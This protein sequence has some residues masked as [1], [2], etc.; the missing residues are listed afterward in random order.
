MS[1]NSKLSVLVSD[2]LDDTKKLKRYPDE[3]PPKAFVCILV[4]YND[5][6]QYTFDAIASMRKRKELAE[7]GRVIS[8]RV[9]FAEDGSIKLD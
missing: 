4:E 9:A 6:D 7:Y 2:V 5:V 8:L 1:I 3:N